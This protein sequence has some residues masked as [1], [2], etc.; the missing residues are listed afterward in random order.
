MVVRVEEPR[1]EGSGAEAR[2]AAARVA[3]W[4]A[5]TEVV[6]MAA[7][8]VWALGLV[9]EAVVM[10]VVELAAGEGEGEAAV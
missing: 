10:E 3:A 9:D 2:V 6:E 4:A 7:A 8:E 1:E 5:E